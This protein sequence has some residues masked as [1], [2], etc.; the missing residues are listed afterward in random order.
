MNYTIS[1]INLIQDWIEIIKNDLIAKGHTVS[2][3]T[4]EN[5]AIS[6]ITY[7]RRNIKSQP[8]TILKSSTFICPAELQDGLNNLEEIISNGGDLKAFLSKQINR[9]G[10]HDKM[11]YDWDIHHFHLGTNIENDGFVS[12]TGPILFARIVEGIVYFIKIG[13][14]GEWTNQ[15]LMS[16][17]EENWPAS[18]ESFKVDAESLTEDLSDNDIKM[19]RKHNIN[20]LISLGTSKIYIGPGQ[21]I[22]AAGG[23]IAS[24]RAYLDTKRGFKELE[25]RI[26]SNPTEWLPATNQIASKELKFKLIKIDGTYYVE[27]V[28]NAWRLAIEGPM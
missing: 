16:I 17:I 14:H 18:I 12:R 26:K 1:E 10:Y 2:G 19:L 22:S 21:G 5:I 28:N 7:L 20:S 13:N 3:L 11:L 15:E 4:D 6:Y 25:K 8:R 23:S 27:E 24:T 9:L